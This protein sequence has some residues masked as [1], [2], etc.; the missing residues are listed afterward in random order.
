[1]QRLEAFLRET[2]STPMNTNGHMSIEAA[3]RRMSSKL[4]AFDEV[5]HNP[6]A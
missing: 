1:M 5:F 3:R 4:E 6:A 2:N